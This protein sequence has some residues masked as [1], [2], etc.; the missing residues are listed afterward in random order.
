MKRF[1]L[2]AIVLIITLTV[3]FALF[4]APGYSG[5]RGGGHSGLGHAV[6]QGRNGG[7]APAAAAG[8]K[9]TGGKTA[10]GGG[11]IAVVS[12]GT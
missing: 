11:A 7:T 4:A 9:A 1:A 8:G 12:T 3:P 10:T 6:C 5:A 2:I